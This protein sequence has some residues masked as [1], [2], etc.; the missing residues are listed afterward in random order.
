MN[1]LDVPTALFPKILLGTRSTTR[2]AWGKVV[3]KAMDDGSW[4]EAFDSLEYVS[5]EEH[6]EEILMC[7]D[8]SP[9][10]KPLWHVYWPGEYWGADGVPRFDSRIANDLILSAMEQF[11]FT[12]GLLG[13]HNLPL[14]PPGW[15][16]DEDALQ[17]WFRQQIDWY[18]REL[19]KLVRWLP[20]LL[21]LQDRF[22]TA[23]PDLPSGIYFNPE[24]GSAHWQN[25]V[26]DVAIQAFPKAFEDDPNYEEASRML[27]SLA[28][29]SNPMRSGKRIGIDCEPTDIFDIL[30]KRKIIERDGD[31]FRMCAGLEDS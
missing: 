15:S 19:P 5:I 12:A 8:R 2:R 31:R 29:R 14:F 22:R 11:W 18:R 10:N 26:Y 1:P 27:A 9:W 4:S 30:L 16:R 17:S 6:R 23:V 20:E 3:R 25:R 28:P 21:S 13:D 24:E 7:G